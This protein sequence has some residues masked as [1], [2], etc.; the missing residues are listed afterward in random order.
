MLCNSGSEAVDTAIKIALQYQ[1]SR[2]QGTRNVI[3]SRERA[4]HGSNLSAVALGGIQVNRQDFGVS[5]LPVVHMRHTW[6]ESNRYQP[7]QGKNGAELAD[8]LLRLIQLHGAQNI[9][10]CIIEPIAGSSGVLVPPVGYLERLR[11]ICDENGVLLI[12]DEVITGFGRTGNTFAAQ[13]FGVIP[14]IMTM[15]KAITN[16]V[17]PMGGVAVRREIYETILDATSGQSTEFFHGYTGSAHPVSCAASLAT[18]EIYDRENLFHRAAELTAFFHERLYC[19]ASY[20]G[21]TDIRAYGMLGGVDIDPAIVGIDGY[22]LQKS[23]FDR[24]LHIKSTGSSLILAPPFVIS[25]DQIDRLISTIE[26]RLEQ[27]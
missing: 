17:I 22:G 3:V 25:H 2:G 8:D 9:A 4:Y 7:G 27:V 23:L 13:S 14:D 16:G 10:A 5:T 21:V 18:L 1:R 24:G 19:L 26:K 15:A 20:R 12:F 11:E 6:L